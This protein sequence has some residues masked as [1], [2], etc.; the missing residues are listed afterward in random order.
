MWFAQP[1]ARGTGR[2]DMFA[3]LTERHLSQTL[4]ANDAAVAPTLEER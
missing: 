4:D 2:N 3:A 1:L